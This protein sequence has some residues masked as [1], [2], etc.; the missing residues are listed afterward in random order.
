MYFLIQDAKNTLLLFRYELGTV[1]GA[2]YQCFKK[3]VQFLS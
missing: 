3:V 2:I 1:S